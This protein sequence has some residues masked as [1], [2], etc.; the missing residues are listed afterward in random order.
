MNG[1]LAF[2]QQLPPLQQHLQ[3]QLQ[4]V[5]HV[6]AIAQQMEAILIQQQTHTAHVLQDQDIIEFA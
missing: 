2:Q 3:L 5:I 4:T 1:V 6:I